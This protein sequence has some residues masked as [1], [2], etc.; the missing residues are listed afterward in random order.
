MPAP[1]MVEGPGESDRRTMASFGITYEAGVYRLGEYRYDRLD[2]ALAH[3][4]LPQTPPRTDGTLSKDSAGKRH[5]GQIGSRREH[6]GVCQ[7]VDCN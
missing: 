1:A 6:A 3:A 7:S 5:P 2:D 4:R